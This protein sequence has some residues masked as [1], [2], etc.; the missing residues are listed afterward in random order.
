MK[1]RTIG[2]MEFFDFPNGTTVALSG[3]EVVIMNFCHPPK[4]VLH[5]RLKEPIPEECVKEM[6][7]GRH[8]GEELAAQPLRPTTI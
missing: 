5:A 1:T 4:G 6:R 3:L 7:N 8:P 2:D